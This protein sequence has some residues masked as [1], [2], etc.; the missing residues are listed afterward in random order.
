MSKPSIDQV[1][2][3]IRS[4]A[5]EIFHTKTGEP[6]TYSV[7]GNNLVPSRTEYTIS[8]GDFGKALALVPLDGPGQINDIV[9]GPAYIWGILHDARVLDQDW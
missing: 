2:T 7:D 5:G 8:Q 1:W 4:L 3:R 9:R 6:F